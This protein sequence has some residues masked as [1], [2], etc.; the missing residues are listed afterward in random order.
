MIEQFLTYLRSEKRFSNHTVRAYENDLVKFATYLKDVYSENDLARADVRHVRSWLASQSE[1]KISSRTIRR[2]ISSLSAFY[3][4]LQKSGVVAENPVRKLPL[5]KI[6][7]SLPKF[8]RERDIV[9]LLENFDPEDDFF[10]LRDKLIVAL[11]YNTG[12]RR[13][14]LVNIQMKDLNLPVIKVKGKRNKERLVPLSGSV[15]EMMQEYI[16]QRERYLNEAGLHSEHLLITRKG[17]GIYPEV[18]YRV[19]KKYFSHP[20]FS[21]KNHPHVLRHSFA[22]AMLNH[23]ADILHVKEIL[24]HSNLNATQVYTHITSENLKSVYLQ[25]HPRAKLSGG[26]KYAN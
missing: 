22:T 5:P 17:T 13:S 1:E 7:T 12:M 15:L 6:Q 25:Y 11:L 16:N 8:I 24:G 10:L 23:G 21:R 2:R 4:F 19:V 9:D 20:N 18:V 26:K 14:E 3:R